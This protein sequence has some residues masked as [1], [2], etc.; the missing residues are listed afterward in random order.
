MNSPVLSVIMLRLVL[1][2]FAAYPH[3][4]TTVHGG[5]AWSRRTSGSSELQ[6]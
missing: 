2:I 4:I 5:R 3:V 1:A 6:D